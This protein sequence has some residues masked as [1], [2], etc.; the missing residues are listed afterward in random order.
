ME[1]QKQITGGLGQTAVK[2]L[3]GARLATPSRL[4][5]ETN[6]IGGGRITPTR[7]FSM[8]W[9]LLDAGSTIT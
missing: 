5:V 4:I 3:K 8:S 6:A 2:K 7:S 1:L 9:M